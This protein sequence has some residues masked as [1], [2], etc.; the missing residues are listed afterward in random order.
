MSDSSTDDH[1]RA[2][3]LEIV[4]ALEN[5]GL[6]HDAYQLHAVIDVE[7]LERIVDSATTDIEVRFTV[8]GYRLLV[9]QTD[10]QVLD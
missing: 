4:D 1:D 5:Q 2:I 10:V 3:L 6:D 8:N 9:T 7:A